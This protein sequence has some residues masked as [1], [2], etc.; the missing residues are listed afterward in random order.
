MNQSRKKTKKLSAG[1]MEIM[2]LLW[3]GGPLTL[4][5]AHAALKRPLGYTTMQTRLNRLV[6]KG[7]AAKSKERPCRY[8]ARVSPED[9]SANHLQQLVERV[10]GGS[11]V[12]LVAHLVDDPSV[13]VEQISELKQ[14]IRQ[15]EKRLAAEDKHDD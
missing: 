14:L 10:T 2:G 11:V 9:V 4:S 12:P 6:E 7:L 13:T 15:A 1:E 3:A 5:E 8:R